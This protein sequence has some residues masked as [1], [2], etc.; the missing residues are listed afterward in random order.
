MTNFTIRSEE[1][2]IGD[3][4]KALSTYKFGREIAKHYFCRRCGIF[5]FV[6]TRLNPGEFRINL[7]C[8]D[9]MDSLVLLVTVFDGE[10]I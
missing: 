7:G 8:I 9:D 6:E 3:E 5:T 10:A 2:E 4:N 1:L